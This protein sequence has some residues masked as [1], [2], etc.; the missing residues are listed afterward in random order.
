MRLAGD[1]STVRAPAPN[2]QMV[3]LT[4][5]TLLV[6]DDF[7]GRIDLSQFAIGM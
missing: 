3:N 2:T 5:I 7:Y 1:V 4:E 6:P